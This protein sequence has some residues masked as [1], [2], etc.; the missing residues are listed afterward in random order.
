MPIAVA[1]MLSALSAAVLFLVAMA[2]GLSFMTKKPHYR[3]LFLQWLGALG[4]LVGVAV[5][6]VIAFEAVSRAAGERGAMHALGIALGRATYGHVVAACVA[7]GLVAAGVYARRLLRV[8]DDYVARSGFRLGAVLA[9]V[10]LVG[11]PLARDVSAAMV[12]CSLLIVVAA[13]AATTLLWRRYAREPAWQLRAFAAVSPLA[14]LVLLAAAFLA[15]LGPLPDEAR[16]GIVAVDVALL[17]L[18]AVLFLR[19]ARRSPD[20]RS[21]E[22]RRVDA[23]RVRRRP[24]PRS[25]TMGVSR[26]A[27]R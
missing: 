20:V 9:L 19:L 23:Q 16:V 13:F 3:L 25:L 14:L 21:P 17:V 24:A 10:G 5:T 7:V 12:L 22:A 2:L 11:L 4:I 27:G 18:T 8:P 26:H 1:V 6:H 15:P